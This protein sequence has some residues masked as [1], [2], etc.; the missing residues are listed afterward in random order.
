MK[1]SS[2]LQLRD[3]VGFSPNFP[4]K[5]RYR[6]KKAPSS[7]RYSIEHSAYHIKTHLR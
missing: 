7:T 1:N 4:F 3:S 2:H 6:S 5:L